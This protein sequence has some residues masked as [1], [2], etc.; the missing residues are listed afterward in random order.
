MWKCANSD[1]DNGGADPK[2]V[3]VGIFRPPRRSVRATVVHIGI[4]ISFFLQCGNILWPNQSP[5]HREIMPLW[6]ASWGKKLT[7]GES[8]V[9]PKIP[10]S[11]QGRWGVG[12]IIKDLSLTRVKKFVLVNQSWMCRYLQ[13]GWPLRGGGVGGRWLAYEDCMYGSIYACILCIF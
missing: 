10:L 2:D 12:N 5:P 3:W 9:Y 8:T 11:G 6:P 7:R 4:S 1:V 13:T